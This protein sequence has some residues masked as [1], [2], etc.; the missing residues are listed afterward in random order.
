M[1][2]NE[3]NEFYKSLITLKHGSY[4]DLTLL[5][6]ASFVNTLAPWCIGSNTV[7]L[8]GTP[9]FIEAN[10]FPSFDEGKHWSIIL[11]L[12]FSLLNPLKKKSFGGH[13][14][15]W[16]IFWS[17]FCLQTL[18][19]NQYMKLICN[20]STWT[21]YM[22]LYACMCCVCVFLLR[23]ESPDLILVY[24]PLISEVALS[25]FASELVWG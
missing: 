18:L 23:R 3:R 17:V 8:E 25:Q 19:Y 7:N 6:F 10:S 20:N 2:V 24:E 13:R 9:S 22:V 15:L 12:G 1:G 11:L 16:N 14:K 21:S 4:V 5:T